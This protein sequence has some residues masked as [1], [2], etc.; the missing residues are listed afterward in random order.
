VEPPPLDNR[1]RSAA[2]GTSAK[3]ES[4]RRA[5]QLLVSTVCR[6]LFPS[7]DRVNLMDALYSCLDRT[8]FDDESGLCSVCRVGLVF[9]A[10]CQKKDA[11]VCFGFVTFLG[12]FVVYIL[13][14]IIHIYSSAFIDG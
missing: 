10:H 4:V 12:F 13:I 6:Q 14:Y 3:V 9:L 2:V 1:D 11:K 5:L 8:S 7:Q